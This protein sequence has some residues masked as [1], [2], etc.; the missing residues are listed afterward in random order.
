MIRK[1]YAALRRYRQKKTVDRKRKLRLISQK[2]KYI[3]AAKHRQYLTKIGDSFINNPKYFGGYHKAILRHRSFPR[4]MSYRNS[5]A[6]SPGEKAE[7]F[8]AYFSPVFLPNTES[9][10]NT[11]LPLRTDMEMSE[12]NIEVNEVESCLQNLNPLQ[13]GGGG[14]RLTPPR[15]KSFITH[16]RLRLQCSYF[17]TFPQIY[18]GTIW[19][20]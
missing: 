4:V 17:M 15:L 13:T 1:K 3:V 11:D 9:K 10:T 19:C 20:C 2:F 7:L 12:M 5:T 6:K 16:E 8:N 18:L 14:G